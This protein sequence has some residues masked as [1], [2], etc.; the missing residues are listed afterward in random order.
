[1]RGIRRYA[2]FYASPVEPTSGSRSQESL[3]C[4]GEDHK[5]VIRH[6][7]VAPC[8]NFRCL[9]PVTVVKPLDPLGTPSPHP[10]ELSLRVAVSVWESATGNAGERELIIPQSVYSA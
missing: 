4:R 9:G 2:C 1:M 10:A 6:R 3:E 8:F 7:N 5:S